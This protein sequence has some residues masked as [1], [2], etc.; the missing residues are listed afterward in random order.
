MQIIPVLDLS[1]GLVVHAKKGSRKHY[2]PIQSSLC[3]SSR[4]VEIIHSFLE[5]YRFR[6]LYI[7]DLDAIE[8]QGHNVDVIQAICLEYPRLEIWL[9]SGLSLINYYLDN[10]K[11]HLLRIILST[12]SIHSASTANSLINHYR[13]HRFIL[14]VDYKSNAVLG[15]QDIIQAKDLWPSDVVVLNLDHVGTCNGMDFPAGLNQKTLFDTH[16]IYY[17]GGIRNCADLQQLKNLG[18]AGA[19]LSTALHNKT[20]TK[21]ELLPFSQ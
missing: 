13:N 14:S 10:Q 4:P 5:L 6:T 19:L 12:E 11:N 15:S 17:G 2:R 8:Q 7:A 18:A 20:I 1:K 16:N 3:P 21:D 9:D